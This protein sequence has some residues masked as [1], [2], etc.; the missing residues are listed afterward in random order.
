[1]LAVWLAHPALRWVQENIPLCG[2]DPRNVTVFGESAG[3]MSIG[4][5]L[6]VPDAD[7]LFQRAVLQSGA[8]HHAIPTATARRI[9][10]HFT[11]MLGIPP[12]R[13]GLSGVS[14]E[15]LAEAAETL[16]AAI[17]ADLDPRRWN[18]VAHNLMPFEPV[19]DGD[20]L[21]RAPLTSI[22]EG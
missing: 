12:T 21:P 18:E 4:A 2:G 13:Q 11:A 15:R 17:A 16:R 1:M 20:L 10:N 19:V 9:G 7:G 14:F 5:L 3:A 22:T 6:A 8:V